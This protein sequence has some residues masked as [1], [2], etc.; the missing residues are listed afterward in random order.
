MNKP[1][2]YVKETPATMFFATF[3]PVTCG[4]F[5][6]IRYEYRVFNYDG[7]MITGESQVDSVRKAQLIDKLEENGFILQ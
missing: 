5:S 2:T 4:G 1:I 7:N 3:V 6:V